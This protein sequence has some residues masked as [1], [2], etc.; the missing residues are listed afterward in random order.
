MNAWLW[1][2]NPMKKWIGVPGTDL[3]P[4][5]AL[6]HY[7]DSAVDLRGQQ[8]TY[9]YWATPCFQTRISL[10]DPA[11]IWLSPNGGIIAA[12]HVVEIPREYTSGEN[13][14]EFYCPEKLAAVGW[15]ESNATSEWK[16]GII[17]ERRWEQPLM[18]HGLFPDSPG[19]KT[20]VAL[21]ENQHQSIIAAIQQRSR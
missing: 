12:G 15:D 21:N 14:G 2:A 13:E 7:L 3:T 10:H 18:V 11:Y 8:V 16:T 1:V 17:I 20:I 6:A 19:A 9:V 5:D 4:F